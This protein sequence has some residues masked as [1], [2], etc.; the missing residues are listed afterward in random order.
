MRMA[1]ISA[2]LVAVLASCSGGSTKPAPG[3]T[4]VSGTV[5]DGGAPVAGALVRLG[6]KQATTAADGTFSAEG[7]PVPYDLTVVNAARQVALVAR[8]VQATSLFVELYGGTGAIHSAELSGNVA[9]ATGGTTVVTAASA[10]ARRSVNASA[11]TYGFVG[12]D[13][14]QWD[15]PA[16]SVALDLRAVQYTPT[17]DGW[18]SLYGSWWTGA[19]TATDGTPST[20]DLVLGGSILPASTTTVGGTV[21]LDAS[22]TGPATMRGSA[23]ISGVSA[24]AFSDA[25]VGGPTFSALL[26]SFPGTLGLSLSVGDPATG[27]GQAFTSVTP[28]Q[29][30]ALALPGA[31]TLSSPADLVTGVGTS[32]PFSWTPPSSGSL[33][34][35]DVY[36]FDATHAWSVAVYGTSSTVALPDLSAL[37]MPLPSSIR[38]SWSVYVWSWT[39]DALLDAT[40][41][42]PAGWYVASATRSFTSQ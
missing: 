38:C 30:V 9:G 5:D 8:G 42:I 33:Q 16:T 14:L 15:G 40:T 37:G 22:W 29:T 25:T 2:V 12:T 6:P 19:A 17:A 1:R 21:A 35:L 4:R 23:T 18:P 36:C 24:T 28:G 11:G 20:A 13:A 31:P 3:G 26:P 10:Q 27:Y 34:E 41:T 7:V 32:T 39:L